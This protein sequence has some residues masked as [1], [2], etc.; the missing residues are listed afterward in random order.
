MASLEWFDAA[1][2]GDATFIKN[3]LTMLRKCDGDG[4]TALMYA[5]RNG[6]TECVRAL[7]SEVGI[8]DAQGYT[9]LVHAIGFNQADA[10]GVLASL[11]ATYGII[12]EPG[13]EPRSALYY[14]IRHESRPAIEALLPL[15]G[16]LSVDNGLFAPAVAV[17]LR[18]RCGLGY[19]LEYPEHV[20]EE[21]AMQ[22]YKLA[23]ALGDTEAAGRLDQAWQELA[24]YGK[25]YAQEL[26]SEVTT[27][28]TP[29]RLTPAVLQ[30]VAAGYIHMEPSARPTTTACETCL[31]LRTQVTRLQQQIERLHKEADYMDAGVNDVT[32]NAMQSLAP[33]PK[34]STV[35]RTILSL[36]YSKFQ[37]VQ[38]LLFE[39]RAG[40]TYVSTY[41]QAERLVFVKCLQEWV[42][43]LC[44]ME[45]TL[46]AACQGSVCL[47]KDS[48]P[49]ELQN[50]YQKYQQFCQLDPKALVAALDPMMSDEEA[51]TCLSYTPARHSKL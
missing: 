17:L 25:M 13:A 7:L 33:I 9:A 29:T 45:V 14:A 20:L 21:H 10:I 22:A 40:K 3:H 12:S 43:D 31:T 2:K 34:T 47:R 19:I 39:A 46:L 41:S 15:L 42:A 48:L 4:C 30:T 37:S 26:P 16:A 32:I 38:Q 50:H 18:R 6:H 35:Y 11:E 49:Q 23:E 1:R 8:A 24:I 44:N 28:Q 36:F 51:S 5:A 27:L